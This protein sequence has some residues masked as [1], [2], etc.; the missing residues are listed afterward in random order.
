MCKRFYV[1]VTGLGEDG[2]EELQ[3]AGIGKNA[4]L[5]VDED[6]R[7]RELVD[8]IR[9]VTGVTLDEMRNTRSTRYLVIARCI[10]VHCSIL[11]G[12]SIMRICKDLRK[13][14]RRIRWYRNEFDNKMAGDIEFRNDVSK[15]L[16]SIDIKPRKERLTPSKKK[17]R[18][19]KRRTRRSA[20][21]QKARNTNIDK[22][23]LTINFNY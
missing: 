21:E 13:D 2:E 18:R 7:N 16:E 10:Y 20:D 9:E 17:R 11:M 23:Q 22:R 1:E 19:K 6:V 5:V 4:I 8:V 14:E 12:D 15:V 3:K